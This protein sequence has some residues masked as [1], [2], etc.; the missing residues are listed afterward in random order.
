MKHVWIVNHYAQE[1]SAVGIVR[2]Y[3]LATNLAHFG[4]TASV[5]TASVEHSTGKQRLPGRVLRSLK[6]LSGVEWLCLRTPSYHGNGIGRIVNMLM[7]TIMVLLPS[8]TRGLSKPQIIIGSTVHPMAAWAA[9][10]LAKRHKVPFVFEVRDLWPLTLIEM[11]AL[12]SS[13]PASRWLY[14]LERWLTD[15]ADLVIVLMP[16]AYEYYQG[17][18]V[19]TDSILTLPNGTQVPSE[20]PAE[21]HQNREF[22]LMYCGAMGSANSLATLIDALALVE[23]EWHQEEPF[24]CRLIGDGPLK[25]EIKAQ[26]KRLG[27]RSVSIEE[28]V[29]RSDVNA[30]LLQADAFVITTNDIPELYRFGVSMNKIF[31]YLATGRPTVMS[32]NVPDNPVSLSG[33]GIVVP[34]EDPR[35]L[36]HAI[37]KLASLSVSDR[38]SMG[39]RA[40]R[41]VLENHNYYHLS[42]RLAAAMQRVV[43]RNSDEKDCVLAD[44]S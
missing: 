29:P 25:H 31:E 3:G 4:W 18:S 22:T 21:P 38:R 20:P 13:G 27:L 15:R 12:S 2:H 35:E 23:R 7:F 8:M 44:S 16:R 40:W 39:L 11:G 37:L 36:A 5:I 6:K 24:R 30:L 14:R 19:S 17:R 33:G 28:A 41:Y 34:P 26:A 32:A 43:E 1:P 10:I 42:G 9:A